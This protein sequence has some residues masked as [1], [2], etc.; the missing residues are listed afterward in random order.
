[1]H[2][3]VQEGIALWLLFLIAN[4]ASA[5]LEIFPW[6]RCSGHC[7]APGKALGMVTFAL[8]GQN[9]HERKR[10]ESLAEEGALEVAYFL[11]VLSI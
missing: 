5:A 4:F 9:G 6:E 8:G 1:M 11:D 10:V 7:P 3:F 2:V